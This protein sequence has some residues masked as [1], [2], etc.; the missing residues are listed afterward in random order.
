MTVDWVVLAAAVTGLGIGTVGAVRTGTGSLASDVNTSLS[1][2]SV[3]DLSDM[4]YM[5]TS[6]PISLDDSQVQ[7]FIQ[8]MEWREDQEL[9]ARY[10]Q[11]LSNIER[12]EARAYDATTNIGKKLT[13]CIFFKA[14]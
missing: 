14:C 6:F 5:M 11:I 13:G 10:L 7:G 4:G 12:D 2:A 9:I 3:A 1:A 8:R